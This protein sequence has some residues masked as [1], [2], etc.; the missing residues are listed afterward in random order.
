[1]KG[2]TK[3]KII[4][5]IIAVFLVFM[6]ASFQVNATTDTSSTN[7]KDARFASGTPTAKRGAEIYFTAGFVESGSASW[8]SAIHF[9]LPAGSGTITAIKVYI[10]LPVEEPLVGSPTT[11]IHELTRTNWVEA[12]VTWNKYNATNDWTTAGGDYSATIIDTVSPTANNAWYAW[13]IGPGATNPISGLTWGSEVHIL[14]K[15]ATESGVDHYW[16]GNS[17]EATT[18]KPYIEITYTTAAGDTCTYTSGNWAVT[19]SDNCTITSNVDLANNNLILTGAGTF[20]MNA[21]I[22]RANQI[23]IDGLCKVAISG[24]NG[25][26]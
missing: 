8:R 7:N 3:G 23:A 24:S 4:F 18:N 21:N 25:F 22:A 12:D 14:F 10:F 17:K 1:V 26:R 16:N 15:D 2:T 13:D 6:F 20:T 5:A 11:N 19:C 9:T